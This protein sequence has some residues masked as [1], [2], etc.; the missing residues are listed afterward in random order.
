VRDKVRFNNEDLVFAKSER[1]YFSK[2]DLEINGKW[3][4]IPASDVIDKQD[5]EEI[6]PFDRTTN[7]EVSEDA[8]V[9][10]DRVPEYTF[11][12]VYQLAPDPDKKVKGIG[13]KSQETC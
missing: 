3:T 10:L 7:I 5:G 9:S 1:R 2:D 6:E 13:N 11:K 8:F 12:E 4:E